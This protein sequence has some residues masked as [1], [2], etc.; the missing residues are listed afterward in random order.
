MK[1]VAIG[2]VYLHE[3]SPKKYIH[4]D[5]K[6]SNILL[7][8]NMEPKIS[9][10]GLGHLAHIAGGMVMEKHHQRQHSSVSS[11][12]V[13]TSALAASATSYYQAPEA[14]KV[15]KPSQK[16]DVYSYGMILLEVITGRSPLVQ[17]GNSEMDLVH[18]LQLCIEE[19]KPL[20][21]IL[22]SY[23]IQES[24]NEEE[25]IAVL[26]IA[27]LCTQSTPDR[28]PSMRHVLDALERLPLSRY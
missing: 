19:K 5:L 12:V 7:D 9:D 6:P 27:M 3:Y 24:D 23:L 13:P 2:L 22:D 11:E 25:M 14:L 10:F 18:W 20:S 16:W 26:K 15:V 4:G 28:R 17:V 21:A 1:E 8:R